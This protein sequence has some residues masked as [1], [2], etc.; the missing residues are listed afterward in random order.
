MSSL[1]REPAAERA[2]GADQRR[3]VFRTARARPARLLGR[4]GVLLAVA[5]GGFLGGTAR[6][7]LD[8]KFPVAPPGFPW[9]I[10]AINVSGSFLL[11]LLMVLVLVVWSTGSLLRPFLA[12]GVLGA[13]TTFSS[14]VLA[15]SALAAA[16]AWGVA[17]SYAAASIG[18]GLL[19]AAVGLTLG[20]ALTSRTR[21][22][23][24]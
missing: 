2:A 15:V 19:A 5:V 12:T 22:T 1:P 16:G 10:F 17:T 23:P 7:L 20:R 13:F 11:G 6:Y 24:E 18:A 14:Y 8:V 9:T 21:T 3:D 4:P